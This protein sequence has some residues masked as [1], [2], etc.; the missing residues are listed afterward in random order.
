MQRALCALAM[1]GDLQGVSARLGGGV[2][3][4]R[5]TDGLQ[6]V[7]WGGPMWASAPTKDHKK[8]SG[9]WAGRCGE[10]TERCQWQKQRSER[11]AAVKISSVRRKA[12]QKFWAP[13]Q[14]HRPLRK[15]IL[16]CVGEGL[17][18]P[19]LCQ[20]IPGH[21]RGRQS[22][23]FLEIASLL[24]PPAAL[25]RFP[26][27]RATARVAPTEGYKRCSGVKNPPVTA[28][29]CQPPLGKG[30]METGDADCH[31]QCA[32][33]L[34]NDSFFARGQCKAGRRGGGTPPYGV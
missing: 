31:S 27:P 8:C 12:A 28:S 26:L 34:R 11:V 29:P 5:P 23:H 10:R 15:R 20:P 13:Q 16:W 21:C 30:A 6:E 9:Y 24:P 2:G 14:G 7:Q 19:P 3:A 32:H 17:S 22:G 25:R 1:T 33:W 18:C 4:P